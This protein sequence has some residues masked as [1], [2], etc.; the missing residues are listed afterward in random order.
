MSIDWKTNWIWT[1]NSKGL[2]N[3]Y[4]DFR[5]VF[6]YN[7]SVEDLKLHISARNEYVLYI[8]QQYIGRGPSPCSNEWQYFDTYDISAYIKTGINVIAAVCYHFGCSD[9][10]TG[11]MQGEA[12]FMLQVEKQGT[13]VIVTDETWKCRYS[14]RWSTKTE[15][16]SKWGGFKEVYIALKE[17]SWTD[18]NYD[19]NLWANAELR[20]KVLDWSSAFPRLIP[21]EIPGLHHQNLFPHGIVRV[22]ENF[23]RVKTPAAT[24]DLRSKQE[25]EK[26]IIDASIPGS[27]PSI[28]F[29]FLR[30]VVGRPIIG[31][32]APEG[33]VLRVAY[34]ESLELQYVDTFILKRGFN[35]LKPFGRRACRFMQITLC[36]APLPVTAEKIEF[37][38]IH[39]D[40]KQTG[41][42]ECD[43]S[44]LNSIWETS[45]YTVLLNSQDHLEDCPWREKALWIADAIVMGKVIYS[46]FGD[47]QLLK[48]CLIQGARIQNEDGS[49]PGTGPESNRFLLPD[50]CAYWALGVIDYYYYSGDTEILLELWGNI[51][52]L[53]SW[54][55]GQLDETGLFCNADREGW[56]CFIDWTEDIDR[57]DKVSAVSFLYYKLLKNLSEMAEKINQD[58]EALLFKEK[59]EA[60]YSN[61]RKHLWVWEKG[62]FAD[63]MTGTALSDNY[64]LQ[65]NFLAIWCDVMAPPETDYFLENYFK[66]NLLPPIRGPFFQHIVLEV[67]IGKSK[68]EEAI[69]LIRRYWGEML[70]RG[71]TTWWETFDEATPHCTI[72]ST[73][74]GNTPTYLWEAPPVSLC[75]GWG[76]SPAYLLP[77][78]VLGV[79]VSRAGEGI[80][81]LDNPDDSLQWARGNFP[82][83]LGDI[84]INW[85]KKDG[86]VIGSIAVPEGLKI[87]KPDNY[88]LQILINT[89]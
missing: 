59:S 88:L 52:S 30:E 23:G 65:T 49:I 3:S 75:H 4:V 63:C 19:A 73:Y 37:E 50:F 20:Y 25:Q 69:R 70:S 33:G 10:V 40:F 80:L 82:V 58:K 44:L 15:R 39:Y 6:H 42:F 54:F 35:E 29:D 53:I 17:D 86:N 11:Q 34:G 77:K 87:I 81:I 43:D 74:Q 2:I 8:N 12:G 84:K 38:A 47:T 24:L 31:I 55:D 22:E 45:R 60:L 28:V 1:G 41:S 48:K 56:W 79:D 27:M 61:I 66:N 26:M 62:L 76:A 13:P 89:C 78:V 83:S 57:R 18:K 21:R 67:L 14:P 5:K 32:N 72:P 64:S 36:A 46:I 68:K 16:I 71:A 9:I 85:E 7:E 51:K